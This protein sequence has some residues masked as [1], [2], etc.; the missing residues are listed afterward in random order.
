MVGALSWPP[1]VCARCNVTSC[2]CRRQYRYSGRCARFAVTIWVRRRVSR[3]SRL[4]WLIGAV[5]L[6]ATLLKRVLFDLSLVTEIGRTAS[7]IGIGS[8]LLLIGFIGFF[9]PLPPKA[10]VLETEQ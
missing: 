2:S 10:M 3:L 1:A 5:L 9:S 6:A 8:M 4:F 7:F